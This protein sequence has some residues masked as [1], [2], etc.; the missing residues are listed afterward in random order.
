MRNS[1]CIW[2]NCGAKYERLDVQ[3]PIKDVGVFEC[4]GCG[5]VLERWSGRRVPAF[6]LISLPET[7]AIDAA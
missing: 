1:A 5:E 3:L 7:K 2:C 6:K 4:H